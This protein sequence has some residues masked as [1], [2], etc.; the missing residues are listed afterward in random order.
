MN[1]NY[2]LLF[3]GCLLFHPSNSHPQQTHRNLIYKADSCLYINPIEGL[4]YAKEAI[5]EISESD[6]RYSQNL[7]LL[8]KLQRENRDLINAEASIL[9]GLQFSLNNASK[10]DFLNELGLIYYLNGKR[11]ESLFNLEKAL[12]L[13]EELHLTDKIANL[14]ITKI[15]HCIYQ[16]QLDSAKLLYEQILPVATKNKGKLLGD[17]HYSIGY[18]FS[19]NQKLDSTQFHYLQAIEQYK[20]LNLPLKVADVQRSLAV[21]ESYRNRNDAAIEYLIAAEEAYVKV[22]LQ[23]KLANVYIRMANIY[24]DTYQPDKAVIYF[25]KA[26]EIFHKGKS[27]QSAA[28]ALM[29]LGVLYLESLNNPKEALNYLNKAATIFKTLDDVKRHAFVNQYIAKAYYDTNNYTASLQKLASARAFYID[30]KDTSELFRNFTLSGKVYHDL[31]NTKEAGKY[32]L[33]A[34]QLVDRIENLKFKIDFFTVNLKHQ[35]LQGNKTAAS[36]TLDRLIATR[37]MLNVNQQQKFVA[38]KQ[39]YYETAKKDEQILAQK[40]KTE[41]MI[42]VVQEQKKATFWTNLT[43]LSFL[44]GLL[45][46]AYFFWQ[47]K[48]NTDEIKRLNLSLATK[49]ELLERNNQ[50]LEEKKKHIEWLNVE[51]NHRIN[52]NLTSLSSTFAEQMYDL[53]GIAKE[54]LLE[55]NSRI[56]AVGVLHKIL[57]H[58]GKK[59]TSVNFQIYIPQLLEAIE[60]V[61]KMPFPIKRTFEIDVKSINKEI[62]KDICLL[63]TEI[64]IN[65][66]KYAFPDHDSPSLK[67]KFLRKH[68]ELHLHIHDNGPGLPKGFDINNTT[69]IG[70]CLIQSFIQKHKGR[71][72]LINENGLRYEIR[73]P[74]HKYEFS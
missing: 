41:A 20:I 63:L 58:E 47:L 57:Y 19:A 43:A 13:A 65:T 39:V 72:N 7:L 15:N 27:K 55:A 73:I 52:N 70:M 46:L 74:E 28:I 24:K 51:M 17:Y 23:S 6:E 60:D 14:K 25:E 67:I 22:N 35:I 34:N 10:I 12:K 3:I 56:K 69:S 37:E 4:R 31:G 66:I 38:D 45:L 53:D 40:A 26:K 11:A 33:K 8:A 64:F 68:G 50:L 21:I 49:N 32:L 44:A 9:K 48:N 71:Y 16:H 42:Q 18:Y 62:G 59:N 54:V 5:K 29:N 30:L 36:K 1:L 2:L 61:Y